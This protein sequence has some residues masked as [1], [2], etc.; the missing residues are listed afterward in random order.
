MPN[1]MRIGLAALL[2]AAVCALAA[3]PAAA[4]RS[5]GFA[6]AGAIEATSRRLTIRQPA[7][8]VI[9]CEVVL[10]GN[11]NAAIAK[12]VGAGVGNIAAAEARGCVGNEFV[13]GPPSLRFLLPIPITY[14]AFLGTL[15]NITGILVRFSPMKF[16]II[17]ARRPLEV[18]CLYEGPVGALAPVAGGEF[19]TLNFLAENIPLREG[20]PIEECEMNSRLVGALTVRPRQR[21]SLL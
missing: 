9:E 15:P 17:E 11:L 10:R 20:N 14:N 8:I 5:L 16:Q 4:L 3:V 18:R 21:V 1:R 7:G 12:T 6:P 13:V 2:L 19:E